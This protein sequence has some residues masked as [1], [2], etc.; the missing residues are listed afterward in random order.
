MLLG[1]L[2]KLN[3]T[4]VVDVVCLEIEQFISITVKTLRLKYP[5]KNNLPNYPLKNYIYN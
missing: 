5:C 4:E 3:V 2:L 1:E